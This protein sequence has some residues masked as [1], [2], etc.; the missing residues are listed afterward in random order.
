[1]LTQTPKNLIRVFNLSEKMKG[2]AKDVSFEPKHIHVIGAGVMGGDIAAWCVLRGM[3]VTLEDR[4]G[5]FLSASLARAAVL[6][7]KKLKDRMKIRMAMDR[8]TPDVAGEG[9]KKADVII[10]AIFENLEAKQHLFQRLE[11]DARADAVLASNT[12]SIP[13]DEISSAMKSPERLVGIHF[14]NPV[15]KMPLVEVVKSDKTDA[16]VV[17]KA[18]AFVVKI[19]RQ[20]IVVK[21]SPGFLVNRVLTPYLMESMTLLEEGVPAHVIDKVAVKFGMPMGPVELADTVGLD[22]CL[23]VAKNLSKYLHTAI[24]ERLVKMVE[25]GQL[26]RKSGRGFYTYKN[27][28]RVKEKVKITPTLDSKTIEQRLISRILNE[29]VACLREHVIDDQDMLDAGMIFGTGFAPFTGGPLNYASSVGIDKIVGELRELE[30][31]YGERF[32][33]DAG[34]ELVKSEK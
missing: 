16:D 26:G 30:I 25:E 11:R 22:I 34:W 29:S 33:P 17:K 12:S 6:F 3:T 2:L 21:S 10:E 28:K 9:V 20:P 1:L 5:K 14:F 24:P 23:S 18:L 19:S 13:L 27:G 32:A 7:K 8:L 31:Q 4:E 15:D